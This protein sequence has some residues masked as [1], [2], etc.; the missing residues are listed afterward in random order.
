MALY[1]VLQVR[2]NWIEEVSATGIIRYRDESTEN[3]QAHPPES[4][5]TLQRMR[6]ESIESFPSFDNLVS[7]R[8]HTSDE[9]FASDTQEVHPKEK[10]LLSN[11]ALRR[12]SKSMTADYMTDLDK[13]NM[14][15]PY[16]RRANKTFEPSVL[17]AV[18][19]MNKCEMVF[20]PCEHKCAC[21][22]CLGYQPP[23]IKTPSK[24]ISWLHACPICFQDVIIMFEDSN[25]EEI[26]FYWKWGGEVT[27]QL[28]TKFVSTF[29]RAGS[30]L[31]NSPATICP[32]VDENQDI[33]EENEEDIIQSIPI[34]ITKPK[35]LNVRAQ[36]CTQM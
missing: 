4:W 7:S 29:K 36:T 31:V 30:K 6:L 3:T 16:S 33:P 20:F 8:K 13:Y 35:M 14:A 12:Q 27:P 28:P 1:V 10:K 17:C 21:N 15:K 23:V 19:K 11:E 22:K 25:G 32:T 26:D 34:S 9:S 24:G 5:N 2:E 18:C